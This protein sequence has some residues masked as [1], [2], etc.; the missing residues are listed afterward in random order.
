MSNR[1]TRDYRITIGI[2]ASKVVITPPFSI[3]FSVTEN[4]LNRALNKL[5]LKITGLQQ[6]TREKLIKFELDKS[7][8]FP[9][10]FEVG[11]KDKMYR[12]FKGSIRI[13]EVNR[14]GATFVNNLECYDGHPDF[15]QAFTS[16]T[17][18]GR[19]LSIDAIL[20][21]MPN[22][23]KGA[24]TRLNET[25][26]P[27]VLVGASS[28]LLAKIAQG[29]E[30]YIKDEKIF[31]LGSDDVVS[32]LAP[33]VSARTGLK[34]VPQQD[35]IDTS[36]TTVLNPSL[37][38]GGLCDIES[39][40]NPGVNGLY[41]IYQIVTSGAYKGTWEQAITCRRAYNYEVVR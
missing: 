18:K 28:D 3:A 7:K 11:Y 29:N 12:A 9:I 32:S 34:G 10:L 2:G 40:T 13:G 37:K 15:T 8:Y 30:F 16:R 26:R 5:N 39:V 23:E 24:I 35:H 4:V 41:K 36:F 14:E 6:S 31:M 27:K 33:L 20:K 1:F 25:I 19:E 22:T 38:I 17:V 21:D